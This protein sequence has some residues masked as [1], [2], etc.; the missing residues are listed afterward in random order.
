VEHLQASKQ[1]SKLYF[2]QETTL[3]SVYTKPLYSN[4]IAF[5]DMTPYQAICP[6]LST[7]KIHAHSIVLCL[8]T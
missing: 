7:L 6:A 8:V 5:P 1:A 3:S 2:Q 4:R